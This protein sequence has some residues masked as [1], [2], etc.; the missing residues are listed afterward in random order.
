MS[1]STLAPTAAL[2]QLISLA[3]AAQYLNVSTLTLQ[4]WGAAGRGPRRVLVGKRV[5]Y[6]PEALTA[7]V[8]QGGMEQVAS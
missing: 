1:D 8:T 4:R 3:T 5:F 7:F 6:T 2:P